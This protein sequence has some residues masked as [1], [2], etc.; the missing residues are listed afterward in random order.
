MILHEV[1]G[2]VMDSLVSNVQRFIKFYCKVKVKVNTRFIYQHQI[3]Q[4]G[5]DDQIT[6]HKT[7]ITGKYNRFSIV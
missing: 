4:N 6:P 7:Y 2:P 1:C 3:N 5:N